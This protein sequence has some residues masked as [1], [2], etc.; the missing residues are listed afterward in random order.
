MC[1]YHMYKYSVQTRHEMKLTQPTLLK[2]YIS[3]WHDWPV[4]GLG[5]AR[6]GPFSLKLNQFALTCT[7]LQTANQST[8]RRG[9]M[10]V[11]LKVASWLERRRGLHIGRGCRHWSVWRIVLDRARHF[12]FFLR[13]ICL[14]HDE[15][16]FLKELRAA[17]DRLGVNLEEH[18]LLGSSRSSRSQSRRI[19]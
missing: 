4:P 9:T 10:W 2:C 1:T 13:R 6:E 12:E 19:W 14:M 7:R 5:G 15:Q 16:L 11:V 3:N 18:L 17:L 8:V